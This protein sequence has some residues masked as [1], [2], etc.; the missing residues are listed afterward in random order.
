MHS[1][2]VAHS[3]VLTPDLRKLIRLLLLIT[4]LLFFEKLDMVS[5]CTVLATLNLDPVYYKK[6]Y[7]CTA[8]Y[9]VDNDRGQLLTELI[10]LF[11][12]LLTS[13][14]NRVEQS[15]ESVL[16]NPLRYQRLQSDSTSK[17]V[18]FL[19]Q[20]LLLSGFAKIGFT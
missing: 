17:F 11:R 19:F 4:P 8:L 15:L 5:Y 20:S 6:I 9:R 14:S 2:S 18:F 1:D 7:S 10:L 13:D 16:L 12:F 3:K